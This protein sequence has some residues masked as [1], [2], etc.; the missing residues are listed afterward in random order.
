MDEFANNVVFGGQAIGLIKSNK[1]I[2]QLIN[3]T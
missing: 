3:M 2:L 1:Y